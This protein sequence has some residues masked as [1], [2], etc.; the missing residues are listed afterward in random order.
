MEKAV[1]LLDFEKD[2][3]TVTQIV[4]FAVWQRSWRALES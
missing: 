2:V 1:A 4:G 3:E